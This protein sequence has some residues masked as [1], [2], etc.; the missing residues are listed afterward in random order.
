MRIANRWY[1]EDFVEQIVAPQRIAN[2]ITCSSN[3]WRSRP[4]TATGDAIFGCGSDEFT[5]AVTYATCSWP[6]PALIR[7][8]SPWA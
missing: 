8:S 7:R 5:E 4:H 1:F 2:S 3:P 6:V